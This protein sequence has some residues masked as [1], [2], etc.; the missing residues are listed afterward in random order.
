[1][2]ARVNQYPWWFLHHFEWDL[3][4][5]ILSPKNVRLELR[6]LDLV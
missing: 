5:A 2:R 1:L 6:H 3:W 4:Q